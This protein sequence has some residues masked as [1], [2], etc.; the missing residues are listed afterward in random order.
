V[1][2]LNTQVGESRQWCANTEHR[3]RRV[4]SGV[5]ILNTEVGE[6]RQWCADTEHRNRGEKT[7]VCLHSRTENRGNASVNNQCETW[8]RIRNSNSFKITLG[9]AIKQE[10]WTKFHKIDARIS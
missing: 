4:D 10:T 1:R 6:S 7:V 3:S 2:I 9:T 5:R 8:P